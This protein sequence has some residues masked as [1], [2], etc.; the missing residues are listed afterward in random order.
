MDDDRLAS[1]LRALDTAAGPLG[2]YEPRAEFVH[3]LHGDLA[4]RLGIGDGPVAVGSRTG[5]RIGPSPSTRRWLLIA[6]TIALLIAAAANIPMIGS[7][8]ELLLERPTLLD[9]IRSS[10]SMRVA[11]RPDQPQVMSSA[12]TLSGF[13]IDVAEALGERIGV[14]IV[15]VVQPV[16]AMLTP[17]DA[18]WQV[19]LPGRALSHTEASRYIATEP[20]YR[21]PAYVLVRRSEPALTDLTG[22]VLCLVAGSPATTWATGS[23]ARTIVTLADDDAC[24]AEVRAGRADAMVSRDLLPVDFETDLEL[25]VLGNSP[26]LVEPRVA[27]VSA[28]ALGAPDLASV[29][30][31]ALADMR[32]DG[33]LTDLSKQRFG[34]LDLS[35][36]DP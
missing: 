5:R 13:D 16:D 33:T 8:I 28:E 17:G 14:E 27:I 22:A 35:Q 23:G 31:G 11:I 18:P 3:A 30:D 34:G 12:G 15:R 24:L 19:A 10:G 9:A 4:A 2:P 36:V 32:D 21:W 6:A 20:Y 29:I 26:V 25:A 7:A 1:R